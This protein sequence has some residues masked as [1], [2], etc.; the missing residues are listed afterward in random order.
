[1]QDDALIGHLFDRRDELTRRITALDPSCP[2]APGTAR[3]DWRTKFDVLAGRRDS[4]R[5][6]LAAMQAQHSYLPRKLAADLLSKAPIGS[7]LVMHAPGRPR[8]EL[9]L[10]LARQ[11]VRSGDVHVT[12][13]T[14]LPALVRLG[15]QHLVAVPDCTPVPMLPPGMLQKAGAMSYLQHRHPDKPGIDFDACLAASRVDVA[16]VDWAMRESPEAAKARAKLDALIAELATLP[17]ATCEALK[18]CTDWLDE[19]RDLETEIQ[20]VHRRIEDVRSS[21]W[22]QFEALLHVLEEAHYLRGRD[23]LARG[24][25]LAHLRTTNELLAAECVAGG[26][27]ENASGTELATIVSCLVAEPPRGRQS[28]DPLPYSA[29]VHQVAHELARIGRSLYRLQG[30]HRVDQP[31]YLVPEYAGLTQAWAEGAP[32]SELIA[33]SGIDEGQLVRHLRQVID[34]LGQL[35]EIPGVGASFHVRAR[36][37]AARI[38]RDIVKEVF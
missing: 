27:L 31:L 13:L 33:R 28:W 34:M 20:H 18:E 37:A 11:P 35:R 3:Q 1:F 17:C 23:L 9:A 24:V 7:W 26:Y 4:L 29:T 22:R 15:T 14:R 8:P 30:K 10:L 38:D 2:I 32:W 12:V 36:E 25:A 5:K 21:H 6:R 19:R 16:E